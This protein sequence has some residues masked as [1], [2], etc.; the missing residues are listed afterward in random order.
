MA[1]SKNM[2]IESK[3]KQNLNNEIQKKVACIVNLF[4]F[5]S[6][7]YTSRKKIVWQQIGSW[8]SKVIQFCSAHVDLI[9]ARTWYKS[10]IMYAG[11]VD[12]RKQNKCDF[13]VF[14]LFFGFSR[15]RNV[16]ASTQRNKKSVDARWWRTSM[17]TRTWLVLDG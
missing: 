10:N 12:K 9:C 7:V 1:W 4:G 15:F 17:R 13:G 14:R 8:M 3:H 2:P 5:F 16:F 11:F 6:G